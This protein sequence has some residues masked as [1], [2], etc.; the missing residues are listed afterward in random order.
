ME[1][2]VNLVDVSLSHQRLRRRAKPAVELTQVVSLG[3][4]Q[5]DQTLVD[6]DDVQRPAHHL[7]HTTLVVRW[8]ESECCVGGFVDLAERTPVRREGH[9]ARAGLPVREHPLQRLTLWNGAAQPVDGCG[10]PVHRRRL[11]PA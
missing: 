8:H 4:E 11:V 2:E 9:C 7:G 6:R 5:L 10:K 1:D 3:L